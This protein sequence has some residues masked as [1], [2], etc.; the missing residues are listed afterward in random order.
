M[1]SM[2]QA[3]EAAPAAR[4]FPGPRAS[5]LARRLPDRFSRPILAAKAA[6]RAAE[7]DDNLALWDFHDL[8]FHARSTEGRHA[9]PSGG[10]Y[11]HVRRSFLRCRR[12]GPAWPGEKIDLCKFLDPRGRT[13]CRSLQSSCGN[14][15]RRAASMMGSRSRLLS[16]HDFSTAPHVFCRS[17]A[18]RAIRGDADPDR[19]T[20][21]P[22]HQQ[23]ASW[24]L[25]L[26]LAVEHLRRA[27]ARLLSLRCRRSCAGPD[28]G[29]R[30]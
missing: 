27:S 24:E 16:F 21:G 17:R 18:V 29:S 15:I 20:L 30:E 7:G 8:L 23:A 4:R 9:N 10:V 3:N 14:V 19:N 2:P 28:R 26:Y 13:P 6:L 5:R 12:C 25:E 1:L 11:P 22:I